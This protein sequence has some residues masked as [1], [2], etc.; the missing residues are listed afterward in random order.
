MLALHL[1]E[2]KFVIVIDKYIQVYLFRL[3]QSINF[4]NELEIYTFEFNFFLKVQNSK[5]TESQT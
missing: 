3:N 2:H 4:S 5:K 1:N